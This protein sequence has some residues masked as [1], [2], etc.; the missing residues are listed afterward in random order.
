LRIDFEKRYKP[1]YQRLLPHIHPDFITLET[2]FLGGMRA[3]SENDFYNWAVGF[4]IHDI[5]KAAAVEYH[6]GESSYNRDIVVEHIRIGYDSITNKTNY[7]VDAGLITGCHHE[8][9]GDREGYGFYGTR[10]DQCKKA[11]PLIK[12][13]HC[14][15][16]EHTAIEDFRALSFFPAKVLEII[17]VFD[18]VT[19]PNR[20]Y[21][22]A[23][24]AEEALAMMR[25]EFI[26]KH[27]KIDIILFDIFSHFVREKENQ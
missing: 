26:N 12:Q 1:F 7:P 8:Y 11:N 21:R 22:K 10:L 16:F 23:M 20:K 17:D 9:Y 6:E 14:I 13:N 3:V 4:L 25:E 15:A 18:S 2:V 5:G 27:Q 19:D 24:T